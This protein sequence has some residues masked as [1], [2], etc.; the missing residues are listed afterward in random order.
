MASLASPLWLLGLAALPVIWWLHRLQRP[1]N[2][3]PVSALFLWQSSTLA[4]AAGNVPLRSDPRW[5]LRALLFSVLLLALAGLRLPGTQSLPLIV[6]FDDSTSMQALEK[7]STR[8]ALA[9]DSL[10]SALQ[11]RDA[12]KRI[13]VRSLGNPAAAIDLPV[14]RPGEWWQLLT[15]WISTRE[16]GSLRPP[17]TLAPGNEYWVVTD[18]SDQSINAWLA[19]TPVSRVIMVGNNANNAALTRLALRRSLSPSEHLLGMLTIHSATSGERQLEIFADSQLISR[20]TLV[21]KPGVAVHH[22]FSVPAA[23]RSVSARM[24]PADALAADDELAIK[25]D[26]FNKVAVLIRGG[27][28]RSL[29]AALSAHAGLDVQARDAVNNPGAAELIVDCSGATV[30]TD[31][32]ALVTH[33]AT[34]YLPVTE[35]V[36]W[37]AAADQLQ[38]LQLDTGWL[39]VNRSVAI[40]ENRIPL[41]SSGSTLL[42]MAS[43]I[44]GSIDVFIDLESPALIRRP[45]YPVLISGLVDLALGRRLL[46]PVAAVWRDP[47]E[48]TIRPWLEWNAADAVRLASL[49]DGYVELAPHLIA[50]ALLLLLVDI[51]I[52]PRSRARPSAAV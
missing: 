32:P 39:A 21:L 45:E 50:I 30:A 23:H 14:T 24:S 36:Y 43:A 51:L 44:P 37:H 26:D 29:R 6:W 8:T 17:A 40:A 12:G 25:L 15:D 20:S 47:R 22:D 5:I 27:C 9:V 13:V 4:T 3:I 31:R 38:Q 35:A 16:S 11:Q 34:A 49:P 7:G 18:G 2:A 48:S 42:V 46:D 28:G 52:M 10:V 33:P 1:D 19:D 41:L